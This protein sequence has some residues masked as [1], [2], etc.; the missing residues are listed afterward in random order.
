[1]P[2]R[3]SAIAGVP[4]LAFR[5]LRATEAPRESTADFGWGSTQHDSLK[6]PA[7]REARPKAPGER[8]AP[9]RADALIVEVGAS[10]RPEP[11]PRKERRVEI[12][13]E[14]KRHV[15]P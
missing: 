1:M 3:Q 2:P 14:D 13:M 15:D 9:G 7:D 5:L 4:S 12:G 11:K 10:E 8:A 6:A